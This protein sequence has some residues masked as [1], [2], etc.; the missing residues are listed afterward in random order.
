MTCTRLAFNC[1]CRQ[2]PL[3]IFLLCSVAN[4]NAQTHTPRYVS[5]TDNCK[6]FYEY[7]P[8]SYDAVNGKYPLIIFFHG[9]GALGNGTTDLGKLL[10]LGLPKVIDDKKLPNS[11]TVNSKTYSFIVLSPQFGY[12][13]NVQDLTA[14]L[15]YAKSNYPVD[16]NRIYV[17]G[18][19]MGGGN[20]W[21]LAGSNMGIAH[22]LAAIVPVCGAR[23]I[24]GDEAE[25]I[26]NTGL[27]VWAT[28]NNRDPDVPV[29][30]TLNNV[31]K[32]NT[33][34]PG[35]TLAVSV[36]YD[37]ADHDAWTRTY[38]P[39]NKTNGQNIYE[40]MLTNSRVADGPLP[41]IMKN[42]S[43]T[44]GDGSVYLK[45]ETTM[46]ENNAVFIIQTSADGIQFTDKFTIP[47]TNQSTG[48]LYTYIDK[49]VSPG[50]SYYRLGQKDRDGKLTFFKA[51]RISLPGESTMHFKLFPNPATN[52]I[53]IN[54]NNEKIGLLDLLVMNMEGKILKTLRFN[55]TKS[56]WQQTI[57]LTELKPGFYNLRLSCGSINVNSSFIKN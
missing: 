11:F 52:H 29:A 37:S 30:Y 20:T 54:L 33:A 41:V 35:R 55:K 7:L 15:Q 24:S 1:F 8:E 43:A 9:F 10:A 57:S 36:I 17:T 51:I 45:W 2:L 28:H 31:E 16:P 19:S 47:A 44:P 56:I 53:S 40:W 22:Q 18:L 21:E 49:N 23:E 32:V 3:L 13:P 46:E 5:I 34:S 50:T 12:W 38:D 4:A 14:V 25:T 26:A 39:L 48:S 27:P 42:F 6:G